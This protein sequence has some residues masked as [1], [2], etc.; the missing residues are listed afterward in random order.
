MDEQITVKLFATLG[1]SFTLPDSIDLT[2]PR[3]IRE[4]LSAADIPEEKVAID[5]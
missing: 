1:R 2:S 3:T 5:I 4:I